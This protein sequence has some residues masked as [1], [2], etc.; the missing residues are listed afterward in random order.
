MPGNEHLPR[1][2]FSQRWGSGR[3]NT[4]VPFP[5]GVC[6]TLAPELRTGQVWSPCGSWLDK[7]SFTGC[8]PFLASPL[9]DLGLPNKLLALEPLLQGLFRRHT[10][11]RHSFLGLAGAWAGA[12][13]QPDRWSTLTSE[14]QRTYCTCTPG[15]LKAGGQ[16]LPLMLGVIL[17]IQPCHTVP[18]TLSQQL[19]PP[20]HPKDKSYRG[21]FPL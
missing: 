1:A 2:A 10:T 21:E 19:K 6:S 14:A 17:H 3:L 7:A 16:N 12:G 15:A 8:H 9:S 20:I 4:P 18:P 13:R 5:S 11:S